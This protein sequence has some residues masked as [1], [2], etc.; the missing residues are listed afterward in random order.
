[1]DCVTIKNG[2]PC[3]F[4]NKKGCT[5]NGGQCKT[6]IEKCE[7]CDRI[8]EIENAKYCNVTPD[9]ATKWRVGTCNLATHM[10]AEKKGGPV[11]KVNPLKASKRAAGKK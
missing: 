1:M 4:M 9:P 7:G 3:T 2:Q 8:L 5:F 11:A 10:K 6:V